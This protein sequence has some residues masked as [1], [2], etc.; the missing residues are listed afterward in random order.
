MAPHVLHVIQ[1]L[2]C[3]GA[4]QALEAL[5]SATE[6]ST[7]E[8]ASL[9]PATDLAREKFKAKDIKLLEH[10]S[11]HQLNAH[12]NAADVV[13]I[14]FWNTPE[15]YDFMTTERTNRY[16]LWSH[17]E[18]ST[19]PHI[20]IP[21]L[22]T[23]C[24]ALVRSCAPLQKHVPSSLV[25]EGRTPRSFPNR[26]RSVKSKEESIVGIFGTLSSTRRCR[27]ALNVFAEAR[28][29]GECLL[30]VGNGDLLPYWRQQVRDLNL[31]GCVEFKGFT[32]DVVKELSRIDVLLHLPRP[33]SYATADLALQEA[34][35]AGVVP[36]VL[37][38][39]PVVDLLRHGIDSLIGDDLDACS[40][41]LRTL[42]S[43]PEQLAKMS[44][45][46]QARARNEFSARDSARAFEQLYQQLCERPTQRCRLRLEPNQ[47]G[48]KRFMASLDEAA[49]P[50]RI[51]ETRASGWQEADEQIASSHPALVG[52]G[53]GG[54]LHYRGFYPE[55]PFL[56]YWAGLVLER[57]GR[58]GLAAAEFSAAA[59]KGVEGASDR[60]EQC[61]RSYVDCQ[62]MSS[63]AS[64]H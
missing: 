10:P 29:S 11:A 44:K 38:G 23:Y 40:H 18:G 41:H 52:P 63:N 16:L 20:L 4:G 57:S 17:V 5:I 6:A 28:E 27:A 45:A 61:L 3:G 15:L 54:I 1:Q 19:T 25:I 59:Q 46:G 56:R 22:F 13:Q 7:H 35:L 37:A 26:E 21:E 24:H 36:V 48:A 39:T 55:D 53:A 50:F 33:E 30:V 32:E 43:D 60:L 58:R 51:S 47:S 12:V 64:N 9:I 62:A 14:H 42:L 8:V 49:T 31:Q 34:M 2:S